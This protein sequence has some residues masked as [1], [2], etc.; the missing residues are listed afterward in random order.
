MVATKTLAQW[1]LL[2]TCISVPLL[3]LYRF[4]TVILCQN[5]LFSLSF[6]VIT[7]VYNM[8]INVGPT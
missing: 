4:L 5:K 7:I 2:G 3:L 1:D 6:I 8:Y